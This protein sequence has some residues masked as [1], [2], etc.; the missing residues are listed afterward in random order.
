MISF[1]AENDDQPLERRRV[2]H[3]QTNHMDKRLQANNI[4][5]Y[6]LIDMFGTGMFEVPEFFSQML[7]V[8]I[9]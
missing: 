6:Y 7:P 8:T 1:D 5:I 9:Q 2:P 4:Y 3:V